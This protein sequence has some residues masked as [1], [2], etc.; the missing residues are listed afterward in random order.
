MCPYLDADYILHLGRDK[1]KGSSK[2][3][4]SLEL[5]LT[6]TNSDCVMI[7]PVGN[8]TKISD[9][10]L[11]DHNYSM[12]NVLDCS[13]DM[14]NLRMKE[15]PELCMIV[16]VNKK[17]RAPGVRANP[18]IDMHMRNPKMKKK[19]QSSL[20]IRNGNSCEPRKVYRIEYT[21]WNT[22]A[23][24]STTEILGASCHSVVRFRE[25]FSVQSE[26]IKKQRLDL[27]YLSYQSTVFDL[28]QSGVTTQSYVRRASVS[29]TH[30]TLPTIYSV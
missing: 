13:W 21:F 28:Y 15:I 14:D 29:Y 27:Q 19:L 7:S 26:K 10:V 3:E 22:C 25:L 23:Y 4:E 20:V 12:N 1:N 16:N 30:L 6:N 8:S 9:S 24:D 2:I 17:E 18:D 11:T 5:N